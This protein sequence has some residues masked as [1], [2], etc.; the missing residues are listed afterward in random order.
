LRK[1]GVFSCCLGCELEGFFRFGMLTIF[2]VG[3]VVLLFCQ[4][5]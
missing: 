1:I 5:H 3:Q 4:L 2:V